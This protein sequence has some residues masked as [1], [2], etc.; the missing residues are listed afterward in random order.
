MHKQSSAVIKESLRAA[1]DSYDY[2]T[3]VDQ[4]LAVLHFL[5]QSRDNKDFDPRQR[6]MLIEVAYDL[7]K[8]VVEGRDAH[9]AALADVMEQL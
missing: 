1:K 3:S 2:D 5:S 8:A 9:V 6:E 7:G 4:C